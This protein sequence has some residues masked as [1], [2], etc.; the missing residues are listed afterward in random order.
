MEN[1]VL[2][3]PLSQFIMIVIWSSI[4]L[5]TIV[6]EIVVSG[7]YSLIIG[8]SAIP[9]LIIAS[10][11]RN[12]GLQITLEVLIFALIAALLNFLFFYYGKKYAIRKKEYPI[13]SLV[14]MQGILNQ[15]FDKPAN[16]QV[17]GMLSVEGKLYRAKS[18]QE[19]LDF[20]E[21]QKVLIVDI[22][23]NILII[24]KLKNINH[25]EIE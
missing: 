17:I 5:V 20:H 3:M 13:I 24:D 9:S 25:K 18:I 14:G 15:K 19:D 22:E 2:N 7:F 16:N 8:L 11:T 12:S 10:L 1:T 23:G 4:I 6:V 21:G